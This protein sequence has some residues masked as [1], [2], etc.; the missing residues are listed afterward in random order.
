MFWTRSPFVVDT[1]T[2]RLDLDVIHEFLARSYWSP[3]IPRQLVE[4]AMQNSLCFGL[5]CESEQIGYAR[6]VTD[7]SSFAYLA[8]VFVLEAWRGRGLSK[9]IV[10][11]IKSHPDLQNL[12]RWMLATRDAHGLYAQFGFTPIKNP[13]RLMEIVD[14]NIYQQLQA[15]QS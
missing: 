6:V 12:R 5:F 10:E 4:R 2:S 3:G 8:D 1:E 14:P 7:K 13:E 15:R 9:F 11:C